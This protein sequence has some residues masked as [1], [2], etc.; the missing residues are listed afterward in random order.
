[1]NAY[2]RKELRLLAPNFFV[3]IIAALS[4]LLVPRGNSPSGFWGALRVILPFIFCPAMVIMLALDSFGREISAGTF[5]QLLAQPTPRIRVWRTKAALL[6]CAVLL[7]WAVWL[8]S[9]S[10]AGKISGIDF[11]DWRRIG[12]GSML[13]L[14]A[15]Y[16]GGLWSV[17]LIRQVAIAF[18]FTLLT[19][20]LILMVMAL[21][22]SEKEFERMEFVLVGLFILY[23]LAGFLFAR[24]LFLRAQDVQWS[25][26]NIVLPKFPAFLNVRLGSGSQR[27]F[28]PRMAMLLREFQLHQSQLIIA[29]GLAV[30][31]LIAIAARNF[32][33]GFK[34]HELLSFASHYFWGL[35]LVMP[36]LVGGAAVAEERKLGTLEG[37]LCLPAR[38]RTQFAIKLGVVLL[39]S[40]LFGTV[41]PLLF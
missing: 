12:I 36:L 16:S 26:G 21:I 32:E 22:S 13:F 27:K 14:V 9:L 18:W 7:I 31:H 3:G 23:G 38:R 28:R 15:A 30:L 34:D 19:P 35:W 40:L 11:S 8:G 2:W 29:G 33:N 10:A 41:M 39:L 25:G 6:G 37:Q 20:F 4:V 17:L 1:M 24:R 5:S